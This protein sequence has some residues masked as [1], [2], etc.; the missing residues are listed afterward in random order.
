MKNLMIILLLLLCLVIALS[1]VAQTSDRGMRIKEMQ[2]EQRVA[3]VIGNSA[4]L[5]NVK[6]QLNR[7]H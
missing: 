6:L 2:T 5:D 1:L 3:F 7:N 4:Y